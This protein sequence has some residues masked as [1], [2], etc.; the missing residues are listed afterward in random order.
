MSFRMNAI[1]LR[2]VENRLGVGEIKEIEGGVDGE[3][4]K[5]K[6]TKIHDVWLASDGTL[7]AEIDFKDIKEKADTGNID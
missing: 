3:I 5:I 4:R 1:V 6:V 2:V 7:I